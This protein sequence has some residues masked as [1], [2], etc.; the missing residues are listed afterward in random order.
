MCCEYT[1]MY[2]HLNSADA[3]GTRARMPLHAAISANIK[4]ERMDNSD[5]DDDVP[6][7]KCFLLVF[8]GTDSQLHF[9]VAIQG[10]FCRLIRII[11]FIVE[12]NRLSAE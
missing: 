2:I 5:D 9:A 10:G 6:I 4:R 11:V 8:M 1:S 3:C 7:A 12:T